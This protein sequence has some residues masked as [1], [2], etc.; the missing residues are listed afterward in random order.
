MKRLFIGMLMLFLAL[1]K[2]IFGEDEVVN[3][4]EAEDFRGNAAANQDSTASNGACAEGKTWYFFVGKIPFPQDGKKYN[5]WVRAQSDVPAN[6]YLWKEEGKKAFGWFRTEGSGKWGWINLGKYSSLDTGKEFWPIYLQQP[7]NQNIPTAQGKLDTVVITDITKASRLE[8][9]FTE[10]VEKKSGAQAVFMDKGRLEFLTSARRIA[11]IPF[12]KTPPVLDGNLDDKC[13]QEAEKLSDFLLV[14]SAG[15]AAEQTIGYIC[16]DGTNLYIAAELLESQMPFLR[17]IRTIRNDSV[18]TDDCLEI[19]IDPGFTQK[20]YYQL[21]INPLG[22]QQ[23][24]LSSK[25]DRASSVGKETL[26]WEARTSLQKDRWITEVTIPWRLLD[27]NPPQAGEI[28]GFNLC[29]EERP[30]K[31][32]SYWNNCGSHFHQPD[33]FGLISFGRKPVRLEAVSFS[34]NNSAVSLSI[35]SDSVQREEVEVKASVK[36]EEANVFDEVKTLALESGK[37]TVLSFPLSFQKPGAYNLSIFVGKKE[38]ALYRVAFPFKTYSDGLVSVAWPPEMRNDNLHLAVNTVQHC[39]FLLANHS[40]EKAPVKDPELVVSVPAGIEIL[41]P[42]GSTHSLYY[43]VKNWKSEKEKR[44]EGLYFR[45]TF[46]LKQEIPPVRIESRRVFSSVLLFFQ[47]KDKPCSKSR[48]FFNSVLSFFQA[49]NKSCN[50]GQVLPIYYYLKAGADR[51]EAK[52]FN[53][54]L[55]PQVKGKQPRSILIHN[56]LWTLNPGPHTWAPYIETMQKVGFNALDAGGVGDN[57]EYIGVMRSNKMKNIGNFWYF[58]WNDQHLKEHPEDTAITY[59]GKKNTS[60]PLSVCP[61]IMLQAN[62]RLLKESIVRYTDLVAKK[63][64]DGYC[65]D[66]EGPNSWQICFCPR[67]LAEFKKFA[68]LSGQEELTPEVIKQKYARPWIL[69]ACHQSSDYARVVR[70]ELKRINPEAEFGVYSGNPSQAT[71]EEYRANWE[72][73]VKYI[74]TAYLSYYSHIPA[75]LDDTFTVG[76]QK[77]ISLLRRSAGRNPL[78]VVATLTPGYERGDM[79]Q[80]TAELNKVQVLRSIATGTEGVSFWW[81]GP[82]DGKYY[83]KLAEASTLIADF[84]EFFLKGKEEDK[85]I[86]L[87]NPYGK[88]VSSAVRSLGN[89]HLVLLFNHSPNE[90]R[91]LAFS[92]PGGTA[93]DVGYFYPELTRFEPVGKIK[94]TIPPLDVITIVVGPEKEVAGLVSSLK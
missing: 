65:W 12:V 81:W 94:V 39:F 70:E 1:P 52:K 80:P 53:L 85:F 30:N 54:V 59:D 16:C 60:R 50:A 73:I 42:L 11:T 63:L 75:A 27:A 35:K 62:G 90:K 67:C 55:L 4:F 3:W 31:E 74:D 43:H 32:L 57:P 25:L 20:D 92:I 9:L 24:T 48:R 37:D 87:E 14:N 45:Y 40:R 47:V 91:E 29:R 71:M 86:S 79:I 21:V 88:N 26:D 15:T 2:V 28:W 82:F 34:N 7:T 17:K 46:S 89:L 38:Q 22:T 78:K 64:S 69:F 36:Y 58:W 68:S 76:M 56:W 77:S 44:K 93:G 19:F 41:D 72:E 6:W 66:L 8:E 10:H 33:R 84:E 49:K 13:W 5:V 51:E 18:W 23:D 83:Q 61:T